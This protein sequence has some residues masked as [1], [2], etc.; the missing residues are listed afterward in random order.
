MFAQNWSPNI[1]LALLH[2]KNI[3]ICFYVPYFSDVVVEFPAA[4]NTNNIL[5]EIDPINPKNTPDRKEFL[6]AKGNQGENWKH[7][8]K[9]V[10]LTSLKTYYTVC[11]FALTLIYLYLFMT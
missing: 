9:T 11:I 1:I 8:T 2:N 3:L 4:S 7:E 5:K 6:V 10:P